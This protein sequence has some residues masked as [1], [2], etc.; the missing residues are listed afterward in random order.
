[1]VLVNA[2]A[3][4]ARGLGYTYASRAAG[5]L[6]VDTLASVVEGRDA[7]DLPGAFSAMQAALRNVGIP[8]AGM[9]AL[10]A[11]DLALWDLKARL[12]GL[13]IAVLLGRARKRVPIYGSGGFTTYDLPTLERQLR[14]WV[15][16][17]IPRV[18]M[19]VGSAPD[20]DPHRVDAARACIGDRA[21]LMV[22]ANGAYSVPQSL[23]LAE[24]F[25]ERDVKWFEEPV[26]SEDL[27]G[28][29]EIRR[30]VP[31]G[32]RVAAGEYGDTAIAIRK[33]LEARCVDVLQADATRCG[34]V[35][36]FLRAAS[37]AHA[38]STPFSAHCAPA[39]HGNLGCSVEAIE[40]LEYF[41]DH[42]RLESLFF[43]GV[44]K[45]REGWLEPDHASPGF[46]LQ[47]KDSD[48]EPFQI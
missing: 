8:G 1:M 44:P 47:L 46:G 9:M 40:H 10:S 30:R 15:D 42:V 22:D 19:K 43:D 32:L 7:F 24:S 14:G 29:A 28:L 13:P 48:A 26:S 41:H 25:A 33:M 45:R 6:I 35:T 4:G 21:Q 38:F 20:Q 2:D 11:V 12:L 37:M 34:G 16:S 5:A 23:E 31:A 17:G 39:L 27:V 18:K 36:G 3:G